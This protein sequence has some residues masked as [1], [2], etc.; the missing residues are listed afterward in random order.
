MRFASLSI[1]RFGALKEREFSDLPDGAV[2]VLGRNESGKSTLFAFLETILYGFLPASRDLH[3]YTPWEEDRIEGSAALRLDDGGEVTVLRRLLSQPQG[4]AAFG[5]EGE[6]LR[7]QP[8]PAV[9]FLPRS[10]FRS[11]Y[12]LT[13]TELHFFDESSWERVQD[14]L[15]G[16]LGA[17][18][19]RPVGEVAGELQKEANSLWRQ[20]RRGGPR[21]RRIADGLRALARERREALDR[22]AKIREMSTRIAAIEDELAERREEGIRLRTFR[23]RAERLGPVRAALLKIEALEEEAGEESAT[24][25]LPESPGERIESLR[26][27]LRDLDERQSA[28]ES[29]MERLSKE[30]DALSDEDRLVLE[31]TAE[32]NRAVEGSTRVRVDRER[33]EE[34]ERQ[35][36][37]HRGRLRE[38]AGDLLTEPWSDSFAAPVRSLSRTVLGAH[39]DK[40]QD[41]HAHCRAEKG[42]AAA[43]EGGV[44]HVPGEVSLIALTAV[45][46]CAGISLLAAGLILGERVYWV[47]GLV[48]A[49]MGGVVLWSWLA[50]RRD[51]G[52]QRKE[53]DLKVDQARA[54]LEQAEKEMK[55]EAGQIAG[56]LESIPVAPAKLERPHPDLLQDLATL[57][58]VLERLE[59]IEAERSDLEARSARRQAAIAVACEAA[60]EGGAED[61]LVGAA[62]LAGRL[63]EVRE[64]SRR[65]DEAAGEIEKMGPE[66]EAVK[67]RRENVEGEISELEAVLSKLGSGDPGSGMDV[68]EKRR[69]ARRQAEEIRD[70]LGREHPD[71]DSLGEEIARAEEARE[72]W[73]FSD[74]ELVR[75]GERLEQVIEEVK[76]LEKETVRLRSDVEHLSDMIT[77]DQIDGE[78]EGLAEELEEVSIR[79]DRLE[80]LASILR[81][82]DQTFREA[83][84]PDVLRRAGSY[85][86][87]ITG[88]R[89]ERLACE[90]GREGPRLEIFQAGDPFPRPAAPPLSSGTLD[91][92][93]LALRLA[94]V[95]HLDD[96]RERLPLFLDEVLVRWDE[97]RMAAAVDLVRDLAS[98]RQV[99]L[100]TCHAWIAGRLAESLGT[101]IIEMP[102]V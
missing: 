86:A 68:L 75:A 38:R 55:E 12:A 23:H 37:R 60:G 19:L 20:D 18:F 95:D 77:L 83:H 63:D 2:V 31:R 72:P 76:E 52:R 90:Q 85:L 21:A 84:Q 1:G 100:F 91:Q 7:N 89:Y 6:D 51:R 9:Q 74:E 26:D 71:L 79:R 22:D 64:R 49:L 93:H 99:F 4:R 92:I 13:M 70:D 65:A 40:F 28:L 81:R 66:L 45:L 46:L 101:R 98:R 78:R 59:E 42:R 33:I 41:L 15:L 96:G 27:Q 73:T 80:L 88:G 44:A 11:V 43:L 62:A 10:L 56:L 61:A 67:E 25:G 24:A 36:E 69:R 30:A 97:G 14:G 39:I 54:I 48:G 35:I 58:D 34:I 47:V 8:L 29:R 17:D 87:R 50:T 3:P 5:D 32:I 94:L 57:Q 16:S 82:A 102:D 53:H